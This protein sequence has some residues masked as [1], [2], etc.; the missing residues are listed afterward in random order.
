MSRSRKKP[1]VKDK[2][3]GA[4]YHRTI[5]R[6]TNEKVRYLEEALDDEGLL[7]P[8]EIVNDYNYKDWE[9]DLRF[10]DDEMSKKASRK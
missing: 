5:R 4:K 6:V 7:D 1:V 2:T 8:K 9:Y 10:R 3:D